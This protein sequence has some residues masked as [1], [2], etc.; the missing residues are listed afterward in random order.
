MNNR[1]RR[2]ENRR[3]RLSIFRF[4]P[5]IEQAN[6]AQAAVHTV[7]STIDYIMSGNQSV[8]RTALAASASQ[9]VKALV[10]GDSVGVG[11]AA[12]TRGTQG[13]V[14]LWRDTLQTAYGAGGGASLGITDE[15][16]AYWMHDTGWSRTGFANADGFGLYLLSAKGTVGDTISRSWD[17]R[18]L[19]IYYKA[20]VSA[21]ATFTVSINGGAAQDVNGAADN[22]YHVVEY[23]AG[24]VGTH[25]VLISAP[26]TA[27]KFAWICGA[28]PYTDTVGVSVI[29]ASFAG[30]RIAT[31]VDGAFGTALDMLVQ[32]NPDMVIFT[33]SINDYNTQQALLATE[34]K[35][36]TAISKNA[37][38]GGS[39]AIIVNNDIAAINAIPYTSYRDYLYRKARVNGAAYISF[40]DLWQR[41]DVSNAA[42]LMG[43]ATHPSTAGHADMH[44]RINAL[45]G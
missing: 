13:W 18:Y 15:L 24:S 27:G 38:A 45:L 25:T 21:G 34:G 28:I 36:T 22:A 37:T 1:R 10:I 26:G 11:W 44:T 4:F 5:Q 30:R 35:W 42:G 41:Y 2:D 33:M 32:I 6:L 40:Y 31:Y 17:G 19:E 43:D 8:W 39:L 9:R 14:P 7:A 16:G 12:T 3:R 20:S 23:D 29:N